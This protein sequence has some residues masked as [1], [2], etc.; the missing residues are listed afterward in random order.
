MIS[1]QSPLKAKLSIC[2]PTFNRFSYLRECIQSILLVPEQYHGHLQVIISDNNSSDSTS[3]YLDKLQKI[4]VPDFLIYKHKSSITPQQNWCAAVNGAK[5]AYILLLSDDDLVRPEGIV[6]FLEN[7]QHY[8]NSKLI[9]FSHNE[10]DQNSNIIAEHILKQEYLD[11]S[12][13]YMKLAMRKI[14]HKLSCLIW[15]KQSIIRNNVFAYNYPS[16]G[17]CLDAAILLAAS[18]N[19]MTILDNIKLCSYRI[20]PLSDTNSCDLKLFYAGRKTLFGYSK[21][22]LTNSLNAA[23]WFYVWNIYGGFVQSAKF[24]RGGRLQQAK[25]MFMQTLYLIKCC[26]FSDLSRECL[27]PGF[28]IIYVIFYFMN[29]L[30]VSGL[31][32]KSSLKNQTIT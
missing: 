1:V 26:K 12:S 19:S 20:H 17:I 31:S 13:L 5:S 3:A 9:I 4:T 25:T 29:T 14:R 27:S 6:C 32:L 28:S 16:S 23:S 11:P 18:C 10:I 22:L 21:K 30:L 15:E 24:L 8:Q 2:I 7:L